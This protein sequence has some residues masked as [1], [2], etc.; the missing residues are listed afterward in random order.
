MQWLNT[1]WSLVKMFIIPWIDY[2]FLLYFSA[3]NIVY[4]VLFFIGAFSVHYRRKEISAEDVSS[5]LHS[6]SLPEI[7]F[8]VPMYNESKNILSVIENLLHLTYRYKQIIVVNDGSEDDCFEV[9]KKNFDLTAIPQFYSEKISTAKIRGIY[10]SRKYPQILA[11]D[12]EHEGKYDAINAG[13]NACTSEFF[14]GVD[15][16]S[17]IDDQTFELMIRPILTSPNMI[18][19]GASVRIRNG[20]TLKY[21]R[22]DAK[23]FPQGYLPAMQQLEYM[24][25]FLMRQGLDWV[26]GNFVIAGVFSIF[27]TD[28][29][30]QI[31]GFCYAG[32][33]EDLEV[34][35][36]LHRLMKERKISYEI[37]YLSDPVSWTE[38]PSTLKKLGKQRIRWHFGLLESIWTHKKMCLNWNYGLMGIGVFPYMIWGEAIEPLIEIAGMLYIL[39]AWLF[40]VL[41]T[42]FFFLF[43]L[44]S[45]GFT[46]LYT[47]ACLFIEELNFRKFSSFR[48][49]LILILCS[50]VEN[51]GYRQLNLLWRTMGFGRF[52][53]QF[54]HV[55]E[56]SKKINQFISKK[57]IQKSQ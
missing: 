22:I 26:G 39:I 54:P 20:C 52:F 13:L 48:T 37:F 10:R 56:L 43:L 46:S 41:D 28:L 34:V 8:I 38:G 44:L 53:K 9:L 42:P 2:F 4:T 17:Y 32:V 30:R 25:T 12:K 21:N 33:A 11:L 6:D 5:I 16:D 45:Y 18:A 55:K 27:S 51:F 50:F 19:V 24:R 23:N 15:A 49:L 7:C 47:I 29:I 31:G 35:V 40:G 1:H 14:I 57:E 36:R 3:V